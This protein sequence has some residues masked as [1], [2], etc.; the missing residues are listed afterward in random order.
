MA[1]QLTDHFTLDEFTISQT[2]ARE[3]IDNTPDAA[4]LR[5]LRALAS[6]LERVRSRLGN[7]PVSI[8]SGYRCPALN[9]AVGGSKTSA[10]MQGLAADFIVPS[11]G[12]VLQTARAVVDAFPDFDQV[13]YEYGRWVHFGL[14]LPGRTPRRELL[15]IGSKGKY[16]SGL[17][18]NC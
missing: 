2:A 14:A 17:T 8:S 13:I 12:T 11:Y 10:H 3:G 7:R 15:S 1:R 6:A 16:V 5:N 4:A 18:T 9:S